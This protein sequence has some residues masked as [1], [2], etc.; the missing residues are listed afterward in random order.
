MQ[1]TE[2][3]YFC[4]VKNKKMTDMPHC[5]NTKKIEEVG[6]FFQND[7]NK[8]LNAIYNVVRAIKITDIN[9]GLRTARNA[10]RKTS[11]KLFLCLLFPLFRVKNPY[12]FPNS[13]LGEIVS[14]GKDQFYRLLNDGSINWRKVGFSV[15]VALSRLVDK[16]C[17]SNGPRCLIADDTDLHKTGR[18]IEMIGRVFSHVENGMILGFKMLTLAYSDGK[19]LLPVDLSLHGEKGAKGNYGMK[20]KELKSRH[21]AEH[22]KGNP[23]RERI[24]EYGKSKIDMLIDMVRR[25]TRHGRKA[26]YLLVD[27]WFVC[28][29]LVAFVLR[30]KSVGHLLGMAKM[31]NTRYTVGGKEKTAKEI[32]RSVRKKSS[33]MTLKCKYAPVRAELKGIPVMLFF[34]KRGRNENWKVMLT[35]DMS[36]SFEQAYKIYAMRWGVEVMFKEAKQ[37]LNLGG[38]QSREFNAQVAAATIALMQ[39][40]ILSVAKRFGCYESLGELFR[41]TEADIIELTLNERLWLCI[42]RI[43]SQLAELMDLDEECLMTKFIT[44]NQTFAKC[45]N[46][47]SLLQS[48]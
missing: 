29:E 42:C 44:D 33:S 11:E 3:Q 7:S 20:S 9:L 43:I 16:H 12:N 41:N 27:S 4:N 35:T 15:F 17:E 2:I 21:K 45:I 1:F 32:I 24:S 13:R 25:F 47:D 10:M 38:C 5:K 39:F 19:T 6:T 36:L 23:D 22:K 34:C 18:H 30:I 40:G 28:H 26:D 37:L 8:A 14:G 31:G 48:A 46:L